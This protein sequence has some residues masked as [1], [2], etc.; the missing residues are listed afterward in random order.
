MITALIFDLDGVLVDTA[1]YHFIAWKKLADELNIPFTETDNEKLKGVSRMD[2][3]D[4]ILNLGGLSLTAEEKM[5]LADRKNAWF[6]EFVNSMSPAEIFPGV[7]ELLQ[8]LRQAGIRIALA[9]SSKNASTVLKLLKIDSL[10]DVV[11]D[12]TMVQQAKPNPELFLLAAKQLGEQPVDCIVVEDAEA[13]VEAAKRAGMKC[14]GVGDARILTK[15][16]WVVAKIADF[17][18]SDL[19]KLTIS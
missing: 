11:V 12:G 6:V 14:I 1:K 5:A 16:D 2:S 15:A 19:E 8:S 13:G 9:S 10:F 3:L 7:K 4:I 17:K 18:L